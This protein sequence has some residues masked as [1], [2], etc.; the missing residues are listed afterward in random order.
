MVPFHGFG[1]LGG[2]RDRGDVVNLTELRDGCVALEE[3]EI[4]NVWHEGCVFYPGSEVWHEV[5]TVSESTVC[6]HL[7][8][9]YW[10]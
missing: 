2:N 3:L 4:A 9:S 1:G 8:S 7:L 5:R 6:S 10:L